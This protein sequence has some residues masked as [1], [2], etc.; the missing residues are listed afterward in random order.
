[1]EYGSANASS[2]CSPSNTASVKYEWCQCTMKQWIMQSIQVTVTTYNSKIDGRKTAK[3]PFFSLNGRSGAGSP[4]PGSAITCMLAKLL[5]SLHT[6][7]VHYF[8]CSV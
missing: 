2:S 6:V 8:I 3:L 5:S 4:R 1:M 7:T